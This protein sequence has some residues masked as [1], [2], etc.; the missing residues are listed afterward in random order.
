MFSIASFYRTVPIEQVWFQA[1]PH[2]G[3]HRELHEIR[4]WLAGERSAAEHE[5]EPASPIVDEPTQPDMTAPAPTIPL[6]GTEPP[7]GRHALTA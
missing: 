2:L 3:V 1:L 6:P 4:S 5:P 7:T